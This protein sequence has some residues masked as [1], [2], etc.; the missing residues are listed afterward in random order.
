MEQTA[1]HSNTPTFVKNESNTT[2]VLYQHPK[3]SEMGKRRFAQFLLNLRDFLLFALLILGA[4]SVITF[5]IQD[6]WGLR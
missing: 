3:P 1:S 4:W 6:L 2:S 5:V